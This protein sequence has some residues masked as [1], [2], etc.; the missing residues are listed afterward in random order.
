MGWQGCQVMVKVAGAGDKA[1]LGAGAV[2]WVHSVGKAG[3]R[4][5]RVK[6]MTGGVM[7]MGQQGKSS[8]WEGLGRVQAVAS[9]VGSYGRA[10]WWEAGQNS[11]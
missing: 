8:G 4:A 11:L 9:A 6:G 3:R 10:S 7:G 2:G 5:S 1:L